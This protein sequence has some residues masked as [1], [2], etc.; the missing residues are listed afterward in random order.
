MR[1]LELPEEIEEMA[2][3]GDIRVKTAEPMEV[4][5]LVHK[6]PYDEMGEALMRL[7]RWISDNGYELMGPPI[8]I[9]H[10]DPMMVKSEE[11]LVTE[12]QFPVKKK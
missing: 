2:E 8:N 3:S 1:P 12:V 5:Y 4:A 6:G 11:E 9:Y 7:L 10:R